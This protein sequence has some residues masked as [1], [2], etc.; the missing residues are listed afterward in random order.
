MRLN[1]T[2]TFIIGNF[3]GSIVGSGIA[4][5]HLRKEYQEKEKEF[6]NQLCLCSQ[7]VDATFGEPIR[8]CP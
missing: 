5:Y 3:I 6:K 8:E 7:M 4:S 2:I 1:V